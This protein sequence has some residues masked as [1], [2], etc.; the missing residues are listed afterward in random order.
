MRNFIEMRILPKYFQASSV[1]QQ[2]Q[3]FQEVI[4]SEDFF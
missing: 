4:F 1:S 2:Q 3:G